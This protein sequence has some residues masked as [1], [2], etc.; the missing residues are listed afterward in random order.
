[1]CDHLVGIRHWRVK[2]IV[3]DMEINVQGQQL[4]ECLRYCGSL[5]ASP[6]CL[7]LLLHWLLPS[8]NPLHWNMKVLVAKR[9]YVSAETY[10]TLHKKWN[11]P[12]KISLVNMTK[13]AVFCRSGHISWRT[14][15]MSRNCRGKKKSRNLEFYFS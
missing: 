11:F 10:S 7:C 13:S 3:L 8:L 6:S 1:M 5:W 2:K 14:Y 12:L 15:L 9:Y 4:G